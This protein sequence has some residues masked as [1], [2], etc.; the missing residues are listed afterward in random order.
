MDA[1]QIELLQNPA[2]YIMSKP[3]TEG[4][5]GAGLGLSLCRELLGKIS[6]KM[7]IQSIKNDGSVFEIILPLSFQV[8]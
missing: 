5:K 2:N 1:D 3:D 7:N 4:E 8:S 6:G